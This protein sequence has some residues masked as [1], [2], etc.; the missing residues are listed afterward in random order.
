MTI[1]PENI[2]KA[3][4]TDLNLEEEEL[5]LRLRLLR[6]HKKRR[7]LNLLKSKVENTK[8]NVEGNNNG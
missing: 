1:P 4:N 5:D 3:D 7:A 2:D 6:L 8:K